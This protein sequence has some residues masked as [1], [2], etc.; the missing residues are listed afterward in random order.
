M[1]GCKDCCVAWEQNRRR[2]LD[3]FLAVKKFPAAFRHCLIEWLENNPKI[4]IG[5]DS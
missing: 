5:I 1:I 4:G 3:A 2:M